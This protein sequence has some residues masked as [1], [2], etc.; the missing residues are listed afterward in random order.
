MHCV[1][2]ENSAAVER[3]MPIGHNARVRMLRQILLQPFFLLRPYS[4]SP[5]A[6][7]HA[8]GVE[9]DHMPIPQIETVIAL[10]RR[11]RLRAPVVKVCRSAT[12]VV[13]MITGSRFGAILEPSPR[14]SVAVA[15]FL[16]RPAF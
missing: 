3:V 15:K 12:R 1:A 4:T 13:F 7:R 8:V 14:C 10:V 11:S 6:G 9:R 5:Y 2:P 16:C